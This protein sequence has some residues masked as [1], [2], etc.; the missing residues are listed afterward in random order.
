MEKERYTEIT[1]KVLEAEAKVKEAIEAMRTEVRT[2]VEP[3]NKQ[4]LEQWMEIA[5]DDDA[6]APPIYD[7]V[8]REWIDSHTKSNGR[9]PASDVLMALAA[10]K[11][12]LD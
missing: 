8:I 11:I 5:G 10:L 1:G 7:M 6:V 4:E 2:V 12:L 3:L 9:L